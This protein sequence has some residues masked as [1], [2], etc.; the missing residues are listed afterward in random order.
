MTRWYDWFDSPVGRLLVAGDDAGLRLVS[1]PNGKSS[2]KPQPDWRRD[3]SRLR[4][5]ARQLAAYFHGSLKAFSLNLVPE[6]TPFQL[7][8][9][10][11][12]QKIPYGQ[13]VSYG[14]VADRMGM[15][16][17]S[18]AVGS[19]CGRNPLSIVIPCHRVIG[20]SGRLIGFGGGLTTKRALLALERGERLIQLN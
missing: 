11:M 9:W 5:V 7:R 16:H 2:H 8:V 10:R 6:G 17:A 19:A 14:Q 4:D 13:T 3:R 12:L 15:A 20:A 1:F 18:R